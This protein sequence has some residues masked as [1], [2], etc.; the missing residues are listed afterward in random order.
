MMIQLKNIT[1][2]YGD[3][4]ILNSISREFK[5]GNKYCL[6]GP[7]GCGKSTL[8]RILAGLSFPKSGEY[9]FNG[10]TITE[11]KLKVKAFSKSFHKQIGFLFQ[12]PSLQ[13]FTSSVEDEIAFGLYQLNY[14]EDQVRSITD[15]YIDLLNLNAVRHQAP[16]T[17][18]GGEKKRTALGAV[19]A[20]EPKV[21]LLDEPLSGLDEEGRDWLKDFIQ[22]LDLKDRILIYTTHEESL[23][24]LSDVTIDMYPRFSL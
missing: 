14:D 12:D 23:E 2:S 11:Q 6:K 17:L 20:M 19:L 8:L 18:S 10:E 9:I 5:E 13:L 1:F 7:N 3:K 15:R 21:L 16:F 4:I 22:N 24:S